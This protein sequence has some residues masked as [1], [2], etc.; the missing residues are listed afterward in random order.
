MKNDVVEVFYDMLSEVNE[1][2]TECEVEQ[3]SGNTE[4]ITIEEIERELL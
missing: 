2:L 1:P 3:L 4:W